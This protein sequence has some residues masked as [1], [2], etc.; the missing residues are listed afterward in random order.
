VARRTR[1]DP[2]REYYRQL[3]KE[4]L[5]GESDAYEWLRARGI[6]NW[7][8]SQW[9]LG[10]VRDPVKGHERFEGS[11]SIP[12]RDAL[13]HE[14]GVRFRRIDGRRPKYDGVFRGTAHLFGVKFSNEPI[15]Y[16]TEGEFDCLILHQMGFKSVGVPGASVW[17]EEWKW[18]FRSADEIVIV[19]DADGDETKEVKKGR[20][21][22]MATG[23]ALFR[24]K[25]MGSLRDSPALVRVVNLPRGHD[26]NSLYLKD[27]KLLRSLLE[28]R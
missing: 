26:I 2:G 1:S 4:I 7:T 28:G 27:R 24:T 19:P 25:I 13:G 12:Y 15:V 10:V 20:P 21:M 5:G 17:R 11:V 8:I 3:V 22:T 23:G 6:R 16:L 14:R 18:L 9:K